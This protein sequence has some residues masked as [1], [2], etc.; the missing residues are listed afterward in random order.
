MRQVLEQARK[1]SMLDAPLLIVGDTGTGKDVLA[2][3]CHLRSP[4][5]KQPFLALNCAAL[6]DDVAESELLAM[7]Q[8]LIL[9]RWKVKKVSSSRLT[10]VRC[11]WM[12]SVK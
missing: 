12:K 6:P 11:C 8:G 10:A 7:P 9:T 3:A 5:G 2:R 4:R 1:L